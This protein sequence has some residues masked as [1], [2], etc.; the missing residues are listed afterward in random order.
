MNLHLARVC[1]RRQHHR[2]AN[3]ASPGTQARKRIAHP[4]DWEVHRWGRKGLPRNAIHAPITYLM[5][6]DP[7]A[8]FHA[9]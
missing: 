7:F 6:Y 2:R 3:K 5:T 8:V 4:I 9:R 1:H